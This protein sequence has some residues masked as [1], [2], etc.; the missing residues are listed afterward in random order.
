MHQHRKLT[1][2]L[3]QS[4]TNLSDI[5]KIKILF[6]VHITVQSEWATLPDLLP[7][8][9]SSGIQVP[10]ICNIKIFSIGLMV[11]RGKERTRKI[12]LGSGEAEK[13]HLYA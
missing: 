10:F 12:S 6:S 5:N 11:F 7:P 3:P 13:C 1:L 4:T 8:K 2:L 9:S